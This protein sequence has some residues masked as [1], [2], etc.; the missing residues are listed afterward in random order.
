MMDSIKCANPQAHANKLILD[1]SDK[2]HELGCMNKAH[3]ER[4]SALLVALFIGIVLGMPL[5]LA[6]VLIYKRV[7]GRRDQGAAKYSRAFYKRADMHDDM[8][9]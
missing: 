7:C 5:T 1:L 4:D 8:H 2:K 9:I 6:C 3:P